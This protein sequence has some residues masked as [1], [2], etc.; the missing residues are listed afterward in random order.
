[1]SA[2]AIRVISFDLDNTLWDVEPTLVR[3]EQAQYDWLLQ[4]RPRLTS[5]F[6]PEQMRDFRFEFHQRHPELTHQISSV[7]REALFELLLQ[8]GYDE[9]SARTGADEAFACFLEIRHQVEPYEEALDI[10]EYL[11][12]D[13]TL[14]ALSN[15]NADI[16]K[17]DIGDHFDFAYSAEQLDA[18]K[19][20]PDMFHA[21]LE[22]TGATSAQVVHVGDNPEHDVRGAQLVGMHT[23]WMNSGGWRWPGHRQ[24]ADEQ[25]TSLK[26][27][28]QA[29]ASIEARL[30]PGRNKTV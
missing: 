29:I 25:I 13:Y 3:A 15:G 22:R 2:R 17:T 20:L 5:H 6:S 24:P 23:V 4:N 8:C 27:L 12:R 26:E 1:M 9:A 11:S 21:C 30:A 7:R 16:F 18:S 14:G 10:L 28:P 19:P